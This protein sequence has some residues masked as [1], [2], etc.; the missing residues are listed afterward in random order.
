M[1]HACIIAFAALIVDFSCHPA[2]AQ[3]NAQQIYLE[4][5]FVEVSQTNIS[6]FGV[7]AE[8]AQL[9]QNVNVNSG[10]GMMPAVQ[11]ADF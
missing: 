8:V 10:M 3:F 11:G 1:K 7:E 6:D 2:S 5:Q 9:F 4:T